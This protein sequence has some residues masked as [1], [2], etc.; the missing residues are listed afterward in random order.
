MIG[1]GNHK[2]VA[3]AVVRQMIMEISG[4]I[5]LGLKE[6]VCDVLKTP[7]NGP[8]FIVGLADKPE[9]LRPA[10]VDYLIGDS[11]KAKENLGWEP[12]TTFDELIKMMLDADIKN[13]S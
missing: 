4:V 2:S 13:F 11:S 7:V 8:E 5:A 10:E 12:K 1:K 6:P 9:F 3:F